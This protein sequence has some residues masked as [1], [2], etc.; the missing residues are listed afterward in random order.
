MVT[1]AREQRPRVFQHWVSARHSP[2]GLGL[3]SSPAAPEGSGQ[4]AGPSYLRLPAPAGTRSVQPSPS[5]SPSRCRCRCPSPSPARCRLSGALPPH[6]GQGRA[7]PGA[8]ARARERAPGSPCP[9]RGRAHQRP[10]RAPLTCGAAAAAQARP[11][12]RATGAGPPR[13]RTVRPPRSANGAAPGPFKAANQRAPRQS[14]AQRAAFGSAR[15]RKE[16]NAA[17]PGAAS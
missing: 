1:H 14:E 6:T 4:R 10:L 5:P 3:H 16:R 12:R 11:Q 8:P 7:V 9:S 17:R 13:V 15:G 2:A